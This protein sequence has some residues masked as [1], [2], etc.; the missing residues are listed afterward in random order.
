MNPLDIP[1]IICTKT[2]KENII[3]IRNGDELTLPLKVLNQHC[4]FKKEWERSF[5]IR[6]EEEISR[7]IK[8]KVKEYQQRPEIKAKKREYEQRPEIKAKRREY[9]ERPEIK[10]KVKE[11]QQRPE[12]KAKKREYYKMK[13]IGDLNK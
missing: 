7:E 2:I 11:Y 4:E 12:R 5:N 3:R 6:H 13:K 10:A 1:D 8:A 9:R